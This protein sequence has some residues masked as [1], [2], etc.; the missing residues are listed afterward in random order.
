[1]ELVFTQVGPWGVI[2]LVAYLFARGHVVPR[3]QLRD[4]ERLV[5]LYRD[6]FEREHAARERADKQLGEM[7]E[8]GRTA[9]RVL[10]ELPTVSSAAKSPEGDPDA[11]AVA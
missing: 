6:A 10:G 5:D 1:M 2:A 8:Y 3:S 11:T 4:R 9:N 7:L